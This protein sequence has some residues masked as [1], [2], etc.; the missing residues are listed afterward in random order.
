MENRTLTSSPETWWARKKFL[1]QEG[2]R[3]REEARRGGRTA[4]DPQIR[5]FSRR[6]NLT[7]RT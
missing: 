2:G 5:M 4:D 3:S 1:K 7:H 6:G